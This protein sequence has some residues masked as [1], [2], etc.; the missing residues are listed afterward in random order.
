M[1]LIRRIRQH[2]CQKNCTLYSGGRWPRRRGDQN[3]S[4]LALLAPLSYRNRGRLRSEF[5]AKKLA[6]CSQRKIREFSTVGARARDRV[7]R[8]GEAD[9]RQKPLAAA[10][11]SAL[12]PIR[13][14][15]GTFC[16][17]MKPS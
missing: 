2:A 3:W 1:I 14:R 16:E 7:G 5:C 9:P 10:P 17:E 15:S 13:L 4:A 6:N 12:A 8:L 11:T